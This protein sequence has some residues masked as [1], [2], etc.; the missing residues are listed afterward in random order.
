[1]GTSKFYSTETTLYKPDTISENDVRRIPEAEE[2]LVKTK[3]ISRVNDHR[4]MSRKSPTPM[5][6]TLGPSSISAEAILNESKA[7]IVRIYRC[8][9]SY[10][11]V[12]FLRSS[13]LDEK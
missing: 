2:T 6:R 9:I 10:D 1:V 3:M 12:C 13:R 5:P 4:R 11:F 7:G 8:G